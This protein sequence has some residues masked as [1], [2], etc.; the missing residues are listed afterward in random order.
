M[1]PEVNMKGEGK[2]DSVSGKELHGS[3]IFGFE[4][5]I[6][7]TGLTSFLTDTSVKMIYSVMPMFLMSIG[8]SKASLGL[9][10]GVAESTASLIKALS[11]FWSDRI[12]RNKPF[13]LIGYAISAIV[14]P[15]YAFVISPMQVLFL[16][17]T[18]RIGKGIRTA[19]RDSLIAASVTN[20]ETG[21]GFGL[22]KAM[23]NSG[24]IAGPLM[25]FALLSLFP[26][27]YRLIFLIAGIPAIAGIFVIIFGIKEVKKNK[28]E[29][30][31][32]FRFT[33]Y[34][35]RY[36][37]FLAIIFVFTLGNSTD[38]LLLVKANE[39][40]IKVAFIP[41]VY[42]I[43]S[44]VSVIAAI[45]AGTLSDRIGKEKLLVAGFLIYAVVYLF[46]GL[47]VGEGALFV[48]FA[49]YG[50]YSAATD[51]IQKAFVADVTDANK[52]GTALGIYNALL[53]ITLL[54]ASLIAG[55]LYD[56]V[57]SSIPFLFGAAMALLATI[58]MAVYMITGRKQ[59]AKGSRG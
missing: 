8:A 20:N 51:G 52:K 57:N 10:E 4:R 25:A 23:D 43:T 44:L 9:I 54:P 6:L 7:F 27:N 31:Q 55:I 45:P 14:L 2:Q 19:P 26:D 58:M 40:G 38:A 46:F 5:N 56:R 15:L 1:Q 39:A 11:G 34:P 41:L 24:A 49:L 21:K 42:L 13:M 28:S 33:D 37:F 17:F 47:N 48:L 16:R 18:E 35:K 32:K 50:L 12:G 59:P 36:W 30:L 29:L 22:Q 3:K 53:G